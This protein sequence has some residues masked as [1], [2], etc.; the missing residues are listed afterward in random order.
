VGWRPKHAIAISGWGSE[1]DLA[2]SKSAGFQ[3]HLIKPLAP[4]ALKMALEG[5]ATAILAKEI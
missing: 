5:I 4:E 1:T 2:K 3:A